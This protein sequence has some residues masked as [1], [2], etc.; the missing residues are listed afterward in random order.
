[1]PA[2]DGTNRG[3]YQIG[4]GRPRKGLAEKINSGKKATVLELPEPA[5]LMGDY[6]PPVKEFMTAQQKGGEDFA[7]EAV[8]KETY[9]WLEKRNCAEL[10]NIQLVEQYAMSV[11]RWVACENYISAYGY[12]AKHPTTGGAIASPYVSM[13]QAYL[14]QANQ[15]WFQ[16]WQVVREN[17]S[18]EYADSA[19]PVD[20]ME[21]LLRSRK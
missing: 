12:L 8:F 21:M 9:S 10:V 14:K 4:G 16:I 3:G 7:A 6:T 13:S 17:C 15:L 2:K 19:A 5:D 20:M 11:A 18:A 1:M